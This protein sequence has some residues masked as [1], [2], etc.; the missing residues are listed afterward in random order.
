VEVA[1]SIKAKRMEKVAAQRLEN[2]FYDHN[3][4]GVF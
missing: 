1:K 4:F 3:D 2:A